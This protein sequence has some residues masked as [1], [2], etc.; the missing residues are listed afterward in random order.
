MLIKFIIFEC[1]LKWLY[2]LKCSSVVLFLYIY[3]YYHLFI[4]KNS[5]TA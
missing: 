5:A 3:G 4:T 2:D 1:S